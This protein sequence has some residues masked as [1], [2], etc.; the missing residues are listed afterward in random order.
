[1]LRR[2]ERLKFTDVSE[3][4]TPSTSGKIFSLIVFI[5]VS[6]VPGMVTT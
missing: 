6:F 2:V 4:L 3:V 1:M 5:L